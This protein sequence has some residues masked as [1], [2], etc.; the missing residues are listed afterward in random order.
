MIMDKD[1]TIEIA[2]K[3]CEVLT[4]SGLVATDAVGVLSFSMASILY[5]LGISRE[6]APSAASAIADDVVF[7]HR[8]ITESMEDEAE[9]AN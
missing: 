7:F 9:E 1:K 6:E 8:V 5:A 3:V 2:D 4:E